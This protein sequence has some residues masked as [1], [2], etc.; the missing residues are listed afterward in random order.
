MNKIQKILVPVDFSEGSADE[1]R[2]AAL[3]AEE[4]RAQLVVL[5]V[6]DKNWR[7]YRNSFF[8]HP[9]T[10]E[11]RPIRTQPTFPLPIDRWIREK[12]LDLYNFIHTTIGDGSGLTVMR[13]VAMGKPVRQIIQVAKEERADLIVL[14]IKRRSVFFNLIARSILIKLSLSS[15]CPVVLTPPGSKD[16]FEPRWLLAR[17]WLWKTAP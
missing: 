13:R 17:R 16:Y 9:A 15:P 6:L 14:A 3:L 5:H 10:V 7:D 8:D 1:L 12:S 4:S 2:Y 11:G